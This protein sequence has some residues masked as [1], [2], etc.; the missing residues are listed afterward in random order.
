MEILET[1][2]NRDNAIK[3]RLN[4]IYNAKYTS[5]IIQ[6]KFWIVWQTWFQTKLQKKL[7]SCLQRHGR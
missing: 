2:A 3:K 4:T 7:K 5:K 1:T 6:N